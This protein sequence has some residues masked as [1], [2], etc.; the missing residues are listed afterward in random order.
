MVRST[1]KGIWRGWP[2]GPVEIRGEPGERRHALVPPHLHDLHPWSPAAASAATTP[3][4]RQ[5]ATLTV[6]CISDPGQRQPQ[7]L[8]PARS[9][10]LTTRYQ[11]TRLHAPM[12]PLDCSSRL[13]TFCSARSFGGS[14][15]YPSNVLLC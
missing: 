3:P 6:N 2:P 15:A 5:H 11:R 12:Q 8:A 4:C 13:I 9:P 1:D 14:W 7:H 10:R